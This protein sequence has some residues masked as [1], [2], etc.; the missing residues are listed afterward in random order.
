MTWTREVVPLA[1][2]LI[3][4]NITRLF[5][6]RNTFG[7]VAF[8]GLIW[9]ATGVFNSLALNINRAFSDASRRNFLENRIVALG[10]FIIITG[11]LILNLLSTT[12]FHFLPELN[13][14][15][16]NEYPGFDTFI[17]Q[18]ISLLVPL[19]FSY[20]LFWALYFWLP[21]TSVH[22][23]AAAIGSLFT[24]IC[25]RLFSILSTGFL[26][27]GFKQY[28]LIYGSLGSVVILMMWVYLTAYLT[29]LGAHLTA[30]INGH[31][32]FEQSQ[33]Q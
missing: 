10:V 6:L 8:I 24:A 1:E 12:L 26:K 33:K 18:V 7:I 16:L 20:L 2:T 13:I 21:K 23:K 4:Q 19:I 15:F 14:P 28:E 22:P 32:K 27:S 31:M 29:L 25:W 3:S 9:S 17:W 30:A 11:L 5:E